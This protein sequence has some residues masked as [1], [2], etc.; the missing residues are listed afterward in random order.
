MLQQLPAAVL[1]RAQPSARVIGQLP[2]SWQLS[3]GA[4][5][6]QPGRHINAR[7][8]R[9]Q[10]HLDRHLSSTRI[11]I[12]TFLKHQYCGRLILGSAALFKLKVHV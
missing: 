10:R 1:V 7:H 5:L 12:R 11:E 6:R 4:G 3:R 8:C 9:L 2:A